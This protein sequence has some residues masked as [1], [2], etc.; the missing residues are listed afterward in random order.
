[1]DAETPKTT[2]KMTIFRKAADFIVTPFN[3]SQNRISNQ[4][5]NL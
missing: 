3:S 2:I 4:D 1:M 5:A